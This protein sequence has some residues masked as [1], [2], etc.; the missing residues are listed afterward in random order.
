MCGWSS[1]A[2][3]SA[4]TRNRVRSSAVAE[5]PWRQHLH[6]H[7]PAERS[8]ASLV[9]HAHPAAAQLAQD[10]R[11]RRPSAAGSTTDR[12][13]APLRCRRR[14]W[15]S[16]PDR[17]R[18]ERSP[19]APRLVGHRRGAGARPVEVGLDP[20]ASCSMSPSRSSESRCS[21][22][23]SREEGW[24]GGVMANSRRGCP[25]QQ[26]VEPPQGSQ[27][28][29][30]R[31]RLAQLQ[32]SSRLL[33]SRVPRN[34]ASTRTSRS[35]SS[36]PP[37]PPGTAGHLLPEPAPLASARDREDSG[38]LERRSIGARRAR[39]GRSRS[40][41]RRPAPRCRRCWSTR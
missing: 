32:R 25:A 23:S 38:Q 1:R 37:E 13:R 27:V 16:A 9:D 26:R 11:S 4:S 24:R 28:P 31:R 40:R 10:S 15:E 19:R 2:A 5:S 22:A 29:H 18:T 8:L 21:S 6:R 30:A 39:P 33:G 14:S 20:S 34:D 17:R 7:D 3:A 36:T 12:Q 41:L 35:T